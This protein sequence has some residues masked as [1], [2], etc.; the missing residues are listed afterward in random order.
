MPSTRPA[1]WTRC[2][3]A[4]RRHEMIRYA[5]RCDCGHRFEA[6]F[7]NAAAYDD[8]EARSL[9]DCPVC[10]GHTVS[11]APMAPAIGRPPRDA[12]PDPARL[13]HALMALSRHIKAHAEDVG[14]NFPEEARSIHEGRSEDRPIWGQATKEEASALRD[15]GIEVQALPDLPDHD[16]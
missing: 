6:W 15:D 9:I 3:P 8:Q 1:S 5:L 4:T 13:R 7:N 2:S 14:T 11:K 16:A 10:G 12:S